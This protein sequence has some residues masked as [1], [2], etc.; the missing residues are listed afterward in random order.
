MSCGSGEINLTRLFSTHLF[1]LNNSLQI[2]HWNYK[3][4][5]QKTQKSFLSILFS[6][7]LLSVWY[8]NQFN[9]LIFQLN[10]FIFLLIWEWSI[11]LWFGDFG[12]ERVRFWSS[13]RIGLKMIIIHNT[14][15]FIIKRYFSEFTWSELPILIEFSFLFYYGLIMFRI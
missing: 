15:S 9:K 14:I 11:N 8:L 10:F 7:F 3:N 2:L 1:I 5:Y 4:Y 13:E 12:D 6:S